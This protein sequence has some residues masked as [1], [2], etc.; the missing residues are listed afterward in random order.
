MDRFCSE[1]SVV[2]KQTI[3]MCDQEV[4]ACMLCKGKD[5]IFPDMTCPMDMSSLGDDG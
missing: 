3:S 1:G 5:A 4:R 2:E